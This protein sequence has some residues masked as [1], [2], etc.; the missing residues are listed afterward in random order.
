MSAV[1]AIAVVVVASHVPLAKAVVSTLT[2]MTTATK[3]D[4]TVVVADAEPIYDWRMIGDP[5][6]VWSSPKEFK[7]GRLFSGLLLTTL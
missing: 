4:K 1:T 6:V 7:L 2:M 3:K 5:V